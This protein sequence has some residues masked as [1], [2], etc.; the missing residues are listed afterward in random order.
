M[1]LIA[2]NTCRPTPTVVN[3]GRPTYINLIFCV[4]HHRMQSSSL[5]VQWKRCCSS[6]LTNTS[7]QLQRCSFL[8]LGVII[9]CTLFRV[10]WQ[11]ARI[12]RCL[13]MCHV[14][15]RINNHV[16]PGARWIID[17]DKSN[18]DMA[19]R[20]KLP[21]THTH[22]RWPTRTDHMLLPFKKNKNKLA[23]L[24]QNSRYTYARMDTVGSGSSGTLEKLRLIDFP[25][26]EKYDFF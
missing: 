1:T 21:V 15:Y 3:G 25:L 20:Y 22:H 26:L 10:S 8:M 17:Q 13:K 6:N 9:S 24:L 19:T 16:L 2:A 12:P 18:M 5:V 23:S 14:S 4:S 11:R 7:T